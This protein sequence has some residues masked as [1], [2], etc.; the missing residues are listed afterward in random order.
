MIKLEKG[1]YGSNMP[2]LGGYIN[3]LGIVVTDIHG[4]MP[5][6]G[7]TY[8]IGVYTSNNEQC[9]NHLFFE[10]YSYENAIKEVELLIESSL[11]LKT[12]E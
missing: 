1:Y 3:N 12:Q 8:V 6:L 10:N 4:C 7:S 11:K 2:Q 9:L 5:K